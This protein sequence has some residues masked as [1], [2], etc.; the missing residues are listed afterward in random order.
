MKV[1]HTKATVE[2]HPENS[3]V[4]GVQALRH[5]TRRPNGKDSKQGTELTEVKEKLGL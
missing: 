2:E 4:R 1:Y 5:G 3:T